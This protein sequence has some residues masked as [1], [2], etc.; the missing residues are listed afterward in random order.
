MTF[1][2]LN[3][4]PPRFR[5]LKGGEFKKLPYNSPHVPFLR[6]CSSLNWA[7]VVFTDMKFDL[8]NC[9]NLASWRHISETIAVTPGA[10][11]G[12]G[13]ACVESV[14]HRPWPSATDNIV[15]FVI[16]VRRQ[17]FLAFTHETPPHFRPE[18][19]GMFEKTTFSR[20]A[21][22]LRKQLHN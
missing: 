13:G 17:T 1:D 12:G 14:L 7:K 4:T 2:I 6:I 9:Q 11:W 19:G 16:A 3:E 22:P 8:M 20:L 5:R 21:S 15:K 18:N 10:V